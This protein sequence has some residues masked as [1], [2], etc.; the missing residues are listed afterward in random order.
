MGCRRPEADDFRHGK[1]QDGPDVEFEFGEVLGHHG[2]HAGVM[3]AGRNLAEKHLVAPDEKL[4]AENAVAAQRIGD[5]LRLPLGLGQRLGS[6]GHRLRRFVVITLDLDVA[7]GGAET[8]AAHRAHRQQGYLVVEGNEFLDDY[9]VC[10]A[11]GSFNGILPGRLDVRGIPDDAL[12]L[13]GGTHGRLDHARNPDLGHS[14]PELI[15]A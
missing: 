13:A 1:P 3:G 4:D 15:Q 11:P 9:L 12:S 5:D 7:D 2:D 8:R 6:H 14:F 10:R